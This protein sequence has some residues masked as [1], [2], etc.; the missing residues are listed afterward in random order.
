VRAG[1]ARN[2]L[3]PRKLALAFST[4]NQRQIA[5]LLKR[6]EERERRLREAAEEL[7]G[8]FAGLRIVIRVRTGENGKLFGSVS[9]MDLVGELAGR[10]IA[11]ERAQLLLEQPL[12]EL[13]QHGVNL[14]LHGDVRAHFTVE[15]VSENPVVMSQP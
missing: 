13:G 2:Y 8:K 6:R 11:V 7:A 9:A 5:A 15:I 10:G 4:A 12:K 3:V 14:R 1:Y